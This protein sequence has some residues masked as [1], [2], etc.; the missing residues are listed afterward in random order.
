GPGDPVVPAVDQY[1]TQFVA[2]AAGGSPTHPI[3]VSAMNELDSSGWPCHV[4]LA[5]DLQRVSGEWVGDD[6]V[7]SLAYTNGTTRLSL[8]EQ[9]GRLDEAEL[10]GF[11][12]K[13]IANARVW[14]RAGY[15]YIVAWD[16]DGV[17]YTLVTDASRAKV[18]EVV[19]QL[20]HR[21]VV[22]GPSHRISDGLDRM[23]TW[24]TPAA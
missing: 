3:A 2:S 6:Q 20:P 15:P 19:A 11:E 22:S 14:V 17:V 21:K 8:F 4:R 7:V 9:T 10:D 23:T 12:A 13:T 18:A 24:L 5:G 16:T 1:A